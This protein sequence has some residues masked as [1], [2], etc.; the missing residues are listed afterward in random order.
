MTARSPITTH[1]LDV[2]LG[3]PAKGIAVRIARVHGDT[4]TELG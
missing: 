1:V 2:S 3:R 4:V